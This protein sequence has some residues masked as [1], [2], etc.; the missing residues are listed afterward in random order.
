MPRATTARKGQP[1]TIRFLAPP[2]HEFVPTDE[3]DIKTLANTQ[4]KTVAQI[5]QLI[6]DLHELNPSGGFQ[7]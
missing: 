7:S 5:K 1:G 3:E 6:S 2:L 4:G